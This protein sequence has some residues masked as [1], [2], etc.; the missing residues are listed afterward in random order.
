MC[1]NNARTVLYLF[2]AS[3]TTAY[4]HITFLIYPISALVL[5]HIAKYNI[6]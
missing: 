2:L 4:L 5:L 1:V 6:T 3:I